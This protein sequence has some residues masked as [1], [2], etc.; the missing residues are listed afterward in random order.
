M[1]RVLIIG[2]SGG[3]GAALA[4][5]STAAGA[6]VVGLSRSADGLDVTDEASIARLLEGVDGAFDRILCTVGQLAPEGSAPEK[7]LRAVEPQALAQLYAVNAIGPLLLLKHLLPRQPRN[8]PWQFAAL[9]ARVGSIGDNHL[10]G[11]YGYRA[12]K[13]ALNQML[14]TAAIEVA[15]THKQATICALH[16]GTVATDFTADYRTRHP[17]VPAAESAAHLLSV[18]DGLTPADTGCFRDWAGKEIPW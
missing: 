11:W 10:G 16:P 9:S 5:A 12:S 2:A 18:L 7:S 15:R 14:R 1:K 6:E 17:A 3:I 4:Q 13:A 8:A